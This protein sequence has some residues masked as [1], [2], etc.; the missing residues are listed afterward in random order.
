MRYAFQ[1]KAEI[2]AALAVLTLAVSGC[3]EATEASEGAPTAQ[4]AA[5]QRT[6]LRISAE[7]TG[8]V[9]PI[10]TVEVKSKASGEILKLHVDTGDRVQPGQLL[11]EVD[12]RDVRNGYEQA[13]ADLEVA[14]ARVDISAAQLE[15]ARELLGSGV[16]TQQE[17]ESSN[18]EA[19]NSRAQLVKAQTNLELA[20]L[21]L[22]DVTI[23]APMA[24]TIIQRNVEVGGV[25]QSASGNISGGT[26]LFLMANLDD[27]QVRTLVDETDVGQLSAGLPATVKV[28]AYPERTFRG[29]VEKIEPQAEVQQNVTMFPVII[30]LDNR[31]GLLKPGMNAEVEVV[32][33][34]QPN[35]LTVPNNAVVEPRQFAPAA[36]AL[37]LD[38]ESLGFNPRAGFA[39]RNGASPADAPAAAAAA[40]APAA[41]ARPA[42]QGAPGAA[43]PG[44]QMSEEQ[45]Q[46]FL[47]VRQKVESGE[48]SQDSARVL[49]RALGGGRPGG[50]ASATPAPGTEGAAAPSGRD[51]RRGIVFVVTPAG[52]YEPR[53]V[54]LGLSDWDQTEVISGVEEGERVALIGAAQLQA[55]QQEFLNR[56]RERN[57]GP[58]GGGGPPGGG[59]R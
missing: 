57:T 38:P 24:G 40:Q 49:F 12:P 5:V 30:Y 50:A 9:E 58:F 59:R 37:G 31:A 36:M 34:E 47:E 22:T 52:S 11:A 45:R 53:M 27:V 25:I 44:G 51:G 46:R 33:A 18:L 28:E 23:R 7:A 8:L 54:T 4:A 39:G 55:Q 20:E 10:R 2:T 6:D 1:Y 21:R 35:V 16:I 43:G 32:V 56:I 41:E 19:A 48:I 15:R 17:Y 14:Q 13:K 26:T 29:D 42:P 3:G